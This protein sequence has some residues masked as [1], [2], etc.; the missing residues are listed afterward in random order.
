MPDFEELQVLWQSQGEGPGPRAEDLVRDLRRHGRKHALIYTVKG[1]VVL[2]MAAVML[3]VVRDAPMAR[4]GVMM[5]LAGAAAIMAVDSLAH[6][7]VG[8][9]EFT[10]SA[11]AFARAAAAALRRLE[12]PHRAQYL[13]FLLGPLAGL[14]VLEAHYLRGS[15]WEVRLAMHLGLS[16]FSLGAFW[17]GFRVRSR[18]YERETRPLLERLESFAAEA[19]P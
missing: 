8:R 4:A 5:V 10:D 2:A 3:V 11:S 1:I 12:K 9:L 6:R 19:H 7:V 18:R 14:N 13:A 17:A 15:D 16:L